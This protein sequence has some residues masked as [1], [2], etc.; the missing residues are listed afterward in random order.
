VEDSGAVVKAKAAD[1]AGDSAV[2]KERSPVEDSDSAADSGDR[3]TSQ[4]TLPSQN[5]SVNC[6]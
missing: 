3:D 6:T 4:Q 2:A 5:C 1:S